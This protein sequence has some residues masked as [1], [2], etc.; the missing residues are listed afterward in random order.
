MVAISDDDQWSG[1]G[2]LIIRSCDDGVDGVE[3]ETT[4]AG[5]QTQ[6]FWFSKFSKPL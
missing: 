2:A 3:I 4:P 6:Q 1:C 5:R